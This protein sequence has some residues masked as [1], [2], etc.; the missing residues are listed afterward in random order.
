MVQHHEDRF[1][2]EVFLH[3]VKGLLSSIVPNKGLVLLEEFVHGLGE[4]GE[5]LNEALIKVSKSKERAYLFNVLGDWPVMDSVEFCGVH[6][7]LANKAKVFD[8][9]FAKFAF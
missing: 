3:F 1:F 5:F 8:L 7:H 9:C 6:H 2:S 4:F